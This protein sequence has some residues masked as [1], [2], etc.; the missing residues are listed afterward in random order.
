MPGR[1]LVA[2]L[3]RNNCMGCKM[4]TF[5][6]EDGATIQLE[7]RPNPGWV[8]ITVILADGTTASA[9]LDP[10]S[11]RAVAAV[12]QTLGTRATP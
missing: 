3:V 5:D 1:Q 11:A 4:I 8:R 6:A 9:L 2:L 7:R 12:L 10:D